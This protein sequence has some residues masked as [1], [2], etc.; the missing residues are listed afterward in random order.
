MQS[1][2]I[3]Q[4]ALKLGPVGR[5]ATIAFVDILINNSIAV[6]FTELSAVF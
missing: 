6:L 4:Q 3:T 2:S 1:M 5:T